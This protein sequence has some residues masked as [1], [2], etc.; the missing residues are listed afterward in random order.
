MVTI[1]DVVKALRL[2]IFNPV[3]LIPL[4]FSLPSA[5]FFTW[6]TILVT[7]ITSVFWLDRYLRRA[8][9]KLDP[10]TDL[11]IITGAGSKNGIGRYIVEEFSRAGFSVLILALDMQW[12]APANT[13]FL[14]CDVTSR[15]DL[16]L[17]QMKIGNIYSKLRPTV[18]INNAGIAHDKLLLDLPD[19]DITKVINVNLFAPFWTIKTFV[20]GMIKRRKGYIVN[21]S[22]VLG[23]IG[24]SQLTAYCASKH[25]LIGLHDALTHELTNPYHYYPEVVSEDPDAPS[26]PTGIATLLVTPGHVNTSMFSGIRC[27]NNFLSPILN[28]RDVG[29]QIAQAVLD[30]ET[31]RLSLPFYT[32]FSWVFSA[33]PGIIGE[34]IRAYSRADLLMS[35]FKNADGTQNV[36]NT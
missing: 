11:I 18:L 8:P 15:E 16:A 9:F 31:G 10:T 6:Y 26:R 20:P 28:S 27:S 25:G 21:V 5:R 32:R 17:A 1:D 4:V 35:G 34:G 7:L 23:T 30:G 33:F 14:V 22:S 19:N 2:S 12:D 36:K 3:V 24:V 29:T 13:T